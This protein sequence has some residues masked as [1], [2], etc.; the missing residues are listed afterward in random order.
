MLGSNKD[1]NKE[2]EELVPA[3]DS[4]ELTGEI[5]KSGIQS[6][7]TFVK[8]FTPWCG[9]CKRLSPTWNTL[10][11]KFATQ[12]SVN[13]FKVNC[14]SDVNKELCNNEK[15][16]GFPTL[17]LYK[18]GVKISEYIGSRSVEDLTHFVNKHLSHDEL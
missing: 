7:I 8:F 1:E 5:F 3:E 18:D 9:H 15:I 14:N 12:N 4:D 2:P 6:G 11:Q 10:R 13:I 16:E 17:F